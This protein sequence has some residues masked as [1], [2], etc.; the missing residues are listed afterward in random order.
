MAA[1]FTLPLNV[2]KLAATIIYIVYLFGATEANQLL[3][4]PIL[5]Q[6][7]N[8]HKAGNASITLA[9]FLHMHYM[10]YDDNDND[11]MRDMQ[12]PFKTMNGCCTMLAYSM[13]AQKSLVARVELPVVQQTYTVLND[14]FPDLF[15]PEDIFQPP[16]FLS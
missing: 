1:C 6:H 11:D 13:P 14:H 5:I 2:R 10:G 15:N 7:Y 8:E 3:K 9:R 4:L 16:R 12:L